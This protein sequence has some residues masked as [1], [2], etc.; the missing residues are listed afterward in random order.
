M[1][2]PFKSRDLSNLFHEYDSLNR[3]LIEMA[4][5]S[6]KY[7]MRIIATVDSIINKETM[8]VLAS[9]PVE[10]L[11]RDKRGIRVKLLHESKAD[12]KLLPI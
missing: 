8:K 6:D 10:E 12:I 5:L 3:Q 11:N 4:S 9:K 7:R 2:R 1:A